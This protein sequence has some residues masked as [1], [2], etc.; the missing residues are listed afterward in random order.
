MYY[1]TLK[2]SFKVDYGVNF[3]QMEQDSLEYQPQNSEE[4]EEMQKQ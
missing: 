1:V 4:E 2:N 3:I